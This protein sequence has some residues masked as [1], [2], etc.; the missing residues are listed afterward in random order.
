MKKAIKFLPLFILLMFFIIMMF[1]A[2]SCSSRAQ[3]V[4]FVAPIEQQPDT[5]IHK[6]NGLARTGAFLLTAFTIYQLTKEDD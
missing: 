5:T 6:G 2:A 3:P 4:S 1:I